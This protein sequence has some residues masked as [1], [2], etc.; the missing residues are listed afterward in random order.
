MKGQADMRKRLASLLDEVAVQEGVH[1]T[2]VEGVE[3][4][5][6]SKSYPRAPMV[7]QP[8]IIVLGQGRKR[9]YLGGEVYSY[10]A[11]NYLTLSVPIPA[12]C[13]TEASPEEPLL[14]VA[15][16]V[17][18]TMLGEVLLEMDEPLKPVGPTP[19]GISTTPMTEDLAGAV[20]RLLE[21]LKTPLDSRLL[22]RQIVREIIYRVLCGEQGNSLRA[23]A[24]RDDHFARIARILK[25]IHS[26]YAKPLGAEEL[27]KKA[28]MSVSA[29]HHNFKLVTGS[30]PLQY[31][32]RIRLDH[33]RR[34]MAHESYNAGTAARA[35]GY[36]SSSQFS[37]EF[38]RLF[39]MSPVEEAEHTRARLAVG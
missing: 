27:A 17:Q 25:H 23:L 20:I 39:G 5:R 18:P 13:E 3:V 33:A 10:D 1:R 7:Y 12:D 8:N 2:L 16:N 21:C 11:F 24:S 15:I 34:L 19:R 9:A 37:R 6:I 29:F 38:K 31:L 22:G 4:A 26:D 14:L 36:E 35:V 32:K 28:G 30:S